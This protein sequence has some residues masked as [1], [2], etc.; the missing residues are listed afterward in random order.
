MRLLSPTSSLPPTH[1]MV[2]QNGEI[3]AEEQV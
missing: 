2:K 1:V 3:L